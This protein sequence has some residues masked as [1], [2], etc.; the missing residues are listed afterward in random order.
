MQRSQ[1]GTSTK[2]YVLTSTLPATYRVPAIMTPSRIPSTAAEAAYTALYTFIISVILLSPRGMIPENRLERHLKRVN[3]D[4]YAMGGE[5]TEKILK[6]M[7]REQYI[8]KVRERDGGGE[9]SVD[10]VVG[11]RGKVEVGERGVAG[12]VRKVYGKKDMEAEELEKKLVRSLGDVVLEKKSR[13]ASEEGEN[14]EEDTA[15]AVAENR[16]VNG[17]RGGRSTRRSSGRTNGRGQNA[18]N[19]DD[20]EEEAE[21]EGEDSDD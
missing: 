21:D 1:G 5:K 12:V 20:E 2:S 19:D 4:N 8:I 15:A 6:R 16:A 13:P 17:V 18:A 10:F 11:P 7:E 9:E 14:E 3:A